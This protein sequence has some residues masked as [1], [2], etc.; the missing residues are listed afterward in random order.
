[1]KVNGARSYKRTGACL[2]RVPVGNRRSGEAPDRGLLQ[3][4]VFSRN[5]QRLYVNFKGNTPAPPYFSFAAM[6]QQELSPNLML[7]LWLVA[8]PTA[9]MGAAIPESD[10]KSFAESEDPT[11]CR[12]WIDTKY[13]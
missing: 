6:K 8:A 3:V 2:L 4:A 9:I 12:S 5:Q 10:A 1:M 11:G 7:I 13:R